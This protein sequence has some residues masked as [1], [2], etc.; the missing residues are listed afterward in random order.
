[1]NR[2]D[3]IDAIAERIGD[4]KKAKQR[5]DPKFPNL[6]RELPEL[7]RQTPMLSREVQDRVRDFPELVFLPA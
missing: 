2:S 6:L 1:M 3:L 7:A 4:R 5:S